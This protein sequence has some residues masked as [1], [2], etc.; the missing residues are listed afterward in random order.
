MGAVAQFNTLYRIHI[1]LQQGKRKSRSL[2]EIF[3][4]YLSQRRSPAR[5]L[6]FMKDSRA[7]PW[8]REKIRR[9]SRIP[10]TL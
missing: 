3:G 7:A 2:P 8:Q 6:F 1:I 9:A 4:I 10:S 5:K